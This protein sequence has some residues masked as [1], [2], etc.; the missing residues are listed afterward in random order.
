MFMVQ[1]IVPTFQLQDMQAHLVRTII[2]KQ[3]ATIWFVK[4]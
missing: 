1:W 4:L 2:R 3:W